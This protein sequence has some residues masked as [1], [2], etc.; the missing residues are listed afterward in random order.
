M[1]KFLFIIL[2]SLIYSNSID[3]SN[4]INENL[5]WIATDQI[6]KK[7]IYEFYDDS[8]GCTFLKI[9]KIVE[10]SE[11]N[12]FNTIVDIENYNNFISNRN[13]E[14]NFIE[15]INDTI[16][17]HQLIKN[18][19]PFIRDRQYI[20]KMYYSGENSI[21]WNILSKEN[22]YLKPF[23]SDDLKT[24]N[25]GAGSWSF[26]YVESDKYLI[27]KIYVNDEV[28]LP[29]VFLN[30]LRKDHLMQIFDDVINYTKKNK[31]DM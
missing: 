6:D 30:K 5:N 7:K 19:V 29:N 20:F 14:T 21:E 13:I 9:E 23:I 28:N 8:C 12:I 17:V 11:E 31:G 22:S 16:F 1:I 18:P 4:K 15:E 25:L 26:A 3:I 24:L 27:N 10:L 2:Y